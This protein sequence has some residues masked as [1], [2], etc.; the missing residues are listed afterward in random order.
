KRG[1]AGESLEAFG[2]FLKKIVETYFSDLKPQMAAPR[3]ITGQDLIE[4][5]NLSPSKLFGKLIDKV[6]EARL[7]GEIKTKK[8]ALEL[9]AG[10][11]RVRS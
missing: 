11:L 5:F 4:H 6:E 1:E 2:H 9:V 8:E 3:F 10:L 7:N